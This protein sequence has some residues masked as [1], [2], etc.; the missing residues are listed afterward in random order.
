MSGV[1]IRT[2][3]SSSVGGRS[4]SRLRG[5]RAVAFGPAVP[6]ELPNFTDLRNH[7]EVEIRHH[8]FVFIPA[9]LRNNLAARI[10]EVAL[11]VKLA[12]APWLL[13][14]DAIDGPHKIAI[15]D[16]MRRLLEFPKIFREAGHGGRR[17]EHDLRAVQSQNARAFGEMAV[18]ADVDPYQ[19]ILCFKDRIPAIPR[20]EVKLFPRSRMA[21]G[22]VMLA[23]F[24]QIAAIGIDYR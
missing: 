17:I 14:A 9:G 11:A 21:V 12:N 20:S 8:H 24:P 5:E 22:N 10:A 16:G 3:S 19:R 23:I 2:V 13:Y 15:S 1:Q 18:V 6:E 7:V 4:L